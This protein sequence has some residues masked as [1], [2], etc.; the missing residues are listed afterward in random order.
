MQK[1]KELHAKNK[2]LSGD[3][4]LFDW[5]LNTITQ[6]EESNNDYSS[7]FSNR[8]KLIFFY[9]S[10]VFNNKQKS[11]SVDKLSNNSNDFLHLK[12]PTP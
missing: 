12:D 1:K 4:K 7:S 2:F 6:L 3:K 5:D 9:H 8:K 10:N 11:L